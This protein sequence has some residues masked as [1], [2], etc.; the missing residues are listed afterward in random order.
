MADSSHASAKSSYAFEGNLVF[1]QPEYDAK[2][3]S[4]K[5]YD[6]MLCASNVK[7]LSGRVQPLHGRSQKTRLSGCHSFRR[8]QRT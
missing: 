6:K 1:L 3:E 8:N 4:T 7:G 2:A 5:D